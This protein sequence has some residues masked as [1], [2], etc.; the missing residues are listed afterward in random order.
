[1]SYKLFF[2]ILLSLLILSSCTQREDPFSLVYQDR[3][4][5]AAVIIAAHQ[6]K[7]DPS[8]SGK[9]FSSGS[10]TAE[11]LIS[12]NADVA[13][14]GDA[15]A[16][17]L[18]ARYPETIILLGIHGGGIDR[19]RMVGRS[20]RPLKIGVK[21]GTSTHAALSSWLSYDADL[22]DLSPSLQLS[23][24]E[25]GEID[26][27]AASEPTPSIAMN[28]LEGMKDFSLALPD[29]I[30][31][32]VL[33]TT[34]KTLKDKPEQIARFIDEIKKA[35]KL[36]E[37][38]LDRDTEELLLSVTGLDEEVLAVSRDFHQF[39]Y[40]PVIEHLE[41]LNTLAQFMVSQGSIPTI[42]DWQKVLP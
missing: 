10:L 18:A 17:T 6:M 33:V 16:V 9:H 15:V 7:D 23:A 12:G 39:N 32:L 34:K 2:M 4:G 22:I 14:M 25:S 24:L 21:F 42:P 38:P 3:V 11:A 41:E 26:A 35:E 28:R 19:H 29:K 1:M 5:D 30:Y 40:E 31:P 27:L 37:G 36:L 8:F 20:D 13:T